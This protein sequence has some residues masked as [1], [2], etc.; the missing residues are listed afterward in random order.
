MSIAAI[1]PARY[2]STRFPGKPLAKLAGRPMI[3]RVYARVSRARLPEEV[4]VATDDARILAAV[5]AFGGQALMTSAEAPTGTDR[6]AEALATIKTELVVNVQGDEPLIEPR[7]ID[8]VLEALRDDPESD[9]VTMAHPIT[10]HRQYLSP[11]VVKVVRD[12][13]GRALYFSRSPLPYGLEPGGDLG[14]RHLGIYA[15]R[16]AAV[17]AFAAAGPGACESAERLEQLRFLELG[18]RIRVLDGPA[19]GPAVDRPEDVA[20]VER[21]LAELGEA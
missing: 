4:W 16:R 17:Q 12:G 15:Y 3:E 8:R 13:R 7:I 6:I 1:I 19:H 9:V 18:M 11:D 14:L 21:L 5:E 10:S 2:G 20:E